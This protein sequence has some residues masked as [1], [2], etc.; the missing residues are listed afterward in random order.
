MTHEDVSVEGDV[1]ALVRS[2]CAL[3]R[4][5]QTHQDAQRSAFAWCLMCLT[6]VCAAL[7]CVYVVEYIV[8][9]CDS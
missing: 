2:C 7:V 1:L 9:C 5:H 3:Q 4:S 8:L 6:L